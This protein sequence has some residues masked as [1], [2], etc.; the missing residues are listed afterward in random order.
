VRTAGHLRFDRIPFRVFVTMVIASL[1]ACGGSETTAPPETTAQLEAET[2]SASSP[3]AS[4]DACQVPTFKASDAPSDCF[5]GSGEPGE[6]AGLDLVG[7]E[8]GLLG[9]VPE[10]ADDPNIPTALLGA[11]RSG[12]TGFVV[13]F[14]DPRQAGEEFGLYLYL[15]LD[16]DATTGL[17][18]SSGA[19]ALPGI[20]RFIGVTLPSSDSWTQAVAKGGYDAEIIRDEAQVF[21]RVVGD[22]VFVLVARALLDDRSVAAW[23]Q[24]PPALVSVVPVIYA[25]RL[26]AAG[27][28]VDAFTLYVGSARST[29]ALDY[30]NG[31]QDFMIPLAMT[32]PEEALYPPCAGGS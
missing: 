1:L 2:Q 6:C 3:T 30:F 16:Q 29:A 19:V 21:A 14:A 12:Y 17:D 26:Y 22:R 28:L 32:V 23:K 8:A 18:M 7:V 20:D 24:P 27:A 5:N 4:G 25:L 10:V 13:N 15:D 31:D 11:A 9:S